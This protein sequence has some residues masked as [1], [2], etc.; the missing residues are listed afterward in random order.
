[1]LESKKTPIWY[2]RRLTPSDPDYVE[3]FDLFALPVKR[4]INLRS[5]NGELLLTTGGEINRKNL[6]AKLYAREPE[7]REGDRCYIYA[8][9]P[10]EPNIMCEGAD[11]RVTSVL[12]DHG[13][14]EVI[15]ERLV[16]E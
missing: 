8:P 2:C 10:E 14:T 13:V 12:P 5:L 15:F 1:M 7:Y 11:Y 4:R 6:V 16:T 3:G 9:L